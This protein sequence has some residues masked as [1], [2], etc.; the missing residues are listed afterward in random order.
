M[1]N[2]TPVSIEDVEKFIKSSPSKRCEL[3]PISI[4]LLKEVLDKTAPLITGI[5]NASL[6]KA[7]FH[8]NTRRLSSPTFE[9]DSFES[10][11]EKLSSSFKLGTHVKADQMDSLRPNHCIQTNDLMEENQSAYRKFHSMETAEVKQP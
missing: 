7:H 10:H 6:T 5:V 3:D 8:K 1:N 2:L 4:N 9:K 11:Q